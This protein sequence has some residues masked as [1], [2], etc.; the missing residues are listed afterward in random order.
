M[1]KF[2]TTLLLLVIIAGAGLFFGWAQLGIPPDGYGVIRSKTHGLYPHLV[3]PG[4]F[5]WIW[6]KLIPTNA[7]TTVLRLNPVNHEFTA[8]NVLPS[9]RIYSTFAG[10]EDD[11]SW[12]M[13]AA[14]SFSIN[15]DAIIPLF[16]AN[17][18]GSQEDLTRYEKDIAGQIEGFILRC[19]D[20]EDN[21]GQ[22]ETL[23]KDGQNPWFEREILNQFPSLHTFTLKIKSAKFPDYA[24]YRQ[25][26]SLF[27]NYMAVQ[28][29]YASGDIRERA[30]N[31]IDSMFRFD[32]LELY[33]SLLTKYPILLEYLALENS[34]K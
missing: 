25:A 11:F 16:S 19:V 24:L 30:K 2:L 22:I 31:R 26:K 6:Y 18:V 13:N 33:G 8:E 15:P 29:E 32:E 20:Q 12:K 28:K 23:L 27:E 21:S 9:G 5:L 14:I 17:T 10:I 1:K 4:E 3:Q 34:K 7:G